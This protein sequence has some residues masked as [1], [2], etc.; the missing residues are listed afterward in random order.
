MAQLSQT[1]PEF[2]HG[3]DVVNSEPILL[4]SSQETKRQEGDRRSGPSSPRQVR[5]C[6]EERFLLLPLQTIVL[7]ARG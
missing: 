7:I 5:D 3:F 6:T 1:V 2:S 4:H